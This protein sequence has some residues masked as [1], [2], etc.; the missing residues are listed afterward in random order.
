M[1]TKNDI[2]GDKLATK[3]ASDAYRDN[4]ERIFGARKLTNTPINV[5]HKLGESV[6]KKEFTTEEVVIKF[7]GPEHGAGVEV[8]LGDDDKP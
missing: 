5:V 8:R 2:T 1:V 3:P 6:L 4:W 7:S